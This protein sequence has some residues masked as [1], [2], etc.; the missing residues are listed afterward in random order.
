[1]SSPDVDMP[2]EVAGLRFRNPFVVGSGPATKTVEQL[3]EAEQSGWAAATLKLTM[4]PPPYINREPRYRWFERRG[5]H[6]FTSDRRLNIDEGLRLTERGRKRT[7]DLLILPNIAYSGPDGIEGWQRMAR[8][9][10][11][12]GAHAIELNLCCPNM[13]FNLDVGG[14]GKEGRPTSGASVGQDA[15]G[16]GQIVA[17][18]R[19]AVDLPLFVKLTPE[20]GGIAEIAVRAFEAGADCVAGTANRLGVPD[21]DIRDPF[22]AT[23]RL[24]NTHSISCLSG[25]W[26]KPLSLR[27]LYEMRVACGPGRPLVGYGGVCTYEDAVQYAMLGADLVGVCTEIMVRGFDF[28]GKLIDQLRSY[29]SEEGFDDWAAMKDL[30]VGRF[31]SADELVL[32]PGHAAID[33]ARCNDCGLCMR[34]GHCHAIEG[35]PSDKPEVRVL[36][37]QACGTCIDICP[38]G[39]IRMV[40]KTNSNEE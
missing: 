10:R 14:R 17:A 7:R 6:M 39:A 22:K 9:F 8:K 24:Q 32:S 31:A 3:V 12:A 19:A 36:D 4:D 34:I 30:L 25:P 33:Q 16:V 37:C 1:M 26:T 38:V 35:G 21:F 18:V 27:D 29:M 11:D 28:L 5:L 2:V 23:Y 40:D 13:S 20:G 15:E